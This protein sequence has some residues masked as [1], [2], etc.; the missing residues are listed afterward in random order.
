MATSAFDRQDI[1]DR[2]VTQCAPL[3][4]VLFDTAPATTVDLGS[5]TGKASYTGYLDQTLAGAGLASGTDDGT[6]YTRVNSAD[7]TFPSP[8]ADGTH[9]LEAVGVYDHT[10]KC[11]RLATISVGTPVTGQIIKILA[12]ALILGQQ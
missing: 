10:G 11:R 6:T 12:S 4:I 3:T 9:D 7:I 2:W 5:L 1:L 8:T